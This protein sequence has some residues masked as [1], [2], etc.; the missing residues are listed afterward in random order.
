MSTV[1]Q[2]LAWGRQRL[3]GNQEGAAEAQILLCHVL[4]KPRTW[5]LTWPETTVEAEHVI[6]Y[7]TLIEQR[8]DGAPVAYLTGRR[9]F[10]T[11]DLAVDRHTLIPRPETELL[12]ERALQLFPSGTRLEV[13]DLGTG[14]GAIALSLASERPH[15]SVT[16]T[17]ISPEALKIAG[18]N[19]R[20]NGIN[21]VDLVESDWFEK[22]HGK[23]D[24]VVSNPPYIPD[25]D[26][27]LQQGD[28][29]HEP[30]RAL[31]S[32]PDG[33]DAIRLMVAQAPSHLQE[34]GWL[35]FEH[36][37]DQGSACREL[38]SL[39]GYTEVFSE[40]DLAGMERISGAKRPLDQ[41][42]ISAED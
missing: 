11:L 35:V 12:V 22:V 24:L 42:V 20:E 18:M 30:R 34:N 31:A 38:L 37:F 36:G 25:P 32:G 26:P 5:L 17:D 8:F 23:F 16:A 6:H 13:L 15:W 14:S 28:L 41:R 2:L 19:A 9:A 3:G 27:H 10:W 29:R 21:N 1:Q 4:Q 40:R 7:Q 33:L 39:S